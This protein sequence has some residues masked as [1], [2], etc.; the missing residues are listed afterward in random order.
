MIPL[1]AIT[2]DHREKRSSVVKVI[3]K[4]FNVTYEQLPHGDY[5]LHNTDFYVER[6]SY[7][8]LYQSYQS[9]TIQQQIANLV[10]NNCKYIVMVHGKPIDL[11]AYKDPLVSYPEKLSR[12]KHMLLS[13]S[14]SGVPYYI[15]A[16]DL[17]FVAALKFISNFKEKTFELLRARVKKCSKIERTLRSMEG[18][19]PV[20]AQKLMEEWG[21]VLTL[22]NNLNKAKLSPNLK[23]E[24][25]DSLVKQN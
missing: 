22:Y 1:D 23:K 20:K 17:E 3:P 6:K 18:I 12:C 4:Y 11:A 5:Y 10:L 16:S 14:C 19:G 24:I 8:D 7:L 9:N 13:L 25:K 2:I 15:A 21:D